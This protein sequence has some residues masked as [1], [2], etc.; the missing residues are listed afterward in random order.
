MFNIQKQHL[1]SHIVWLIFIVAIAIVKFYFHELWKDEWQAWFVA[2]DKSVPEIFSF[3]YYEGH[4]S[5]WYIC[6]KLFTLF[7]GWASDDALINVAH[8]LTVAAG[9][10]FLIVKFRLP[11]LYKVLFALSYFLFFEYGIVNRGYFLVILLVFWSVWLIAKEDYKERNLGV[12]LFML[13]QTEIYGVLMAISL[14]LYVVSTRRNFTKILSSKAAIGLGSGMVLFIIS[15]YPRTTGHIG[16]TANKALTFSDQALS[17]FQ[18]NLSNTYLLGSTPD[19]FTYGWSAVG[20]LISLAC[21]VGLWYIFKSHKSALLVGGAFLLAMITFST[22]VYLGGV[23]QWGMGFVFLIALLE[24]RQFN[25]LKEKLSAFI[26][27]I[28]C[29]FNIVHCATAIHEEINIPFSNAKQAGLYIAEKVPEKVPVVAM[30]KFEATP[31]IGY[32]GRKFYELPSG[33][34]FS[35]FRWVDKIYLPTE[36]E[37]K[38]FTKYKQ[39]GGIILLS[40]NPIDQQRFPS[41]QLWQKFDDVNFKKENYFLYTLPLQ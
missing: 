3:L 23:R 20:I 32:A 37:L 13:C 21:L 30:N 31:V 36:S 18:G 11:L 17:A 35:Y 14:G 5:L 19:T 15:V 1:A 22:F 4:P 27:G 41:A 6:L 7:D 25:P 26:V 8:L 39:V 28:F 2:K 34:E 29:I 12:L 40:P 16:K 38:L 33:T 9:L 24:L 10:Y